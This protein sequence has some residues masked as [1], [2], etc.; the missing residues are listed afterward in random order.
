[1]PVTVVVG[2]QYGSEGKGKMVSY[3]SCAA[4]DPTSVVRCGGSNAGHTAQGFGQ[5]L[6][7][8]QVPSGVVNKNCSLYLAAGM[9]ID[10]PVL[11]AEI[12][13]TSLDPSRLRI[14][15]NAIVMRQDDSNA[16]K[17]AGLRDRIGSTLSG[18]GFATARKVLR[19]EGVDLARTV[20]Q[21]KG[22]IS[23]V[24]EQ[25]NDAVDRGEHVIVEGTQG[26][27]LSLHHADH[28]PYVTSRDTTA[29]A[30]LS[31][32]GLAPALVTETILVLRTYPIR[33]AGKSGHMY[34][35]IT[36]DDVRQ[37]SGYPYP[38]A[39]YTTVTNALRRI[40]EFDWELAEQAVRLNRPTAI[41][42]HGA[43]YID[44]LDYGKRDWTLLGAKSRAFI[45]EIETRLNTIV[46]YVFTGPKEG[47]LIDRGVSAQTKIRR[48]VSVA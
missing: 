19:Q 21:L 2:G 31:D 33:V 22:F 30:F 8:R 10:L 32:A 15:R 18:T 4:S 37:R 12:E 38:I 7:L 42:I 44:Y 13:L 9:V 3:L 45:D 48:A 23:N 35:E 25:I 14:D 16:E 41:A 28:Y 26:M 40:G 20:P 46:G 6:R 36:W 17:H 47:Q 29:S 34:L 43:D 1:M 5:T 39:E 27:G 24:S 11:L